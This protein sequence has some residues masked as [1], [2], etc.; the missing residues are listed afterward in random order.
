MSVS[1]T[2]YG[3]LTKQIR[4]DASPEVVYEVVSTPEHI[5]Q[6]WFDEA[7]FDPTEGSTGVLRMG[8]ATDRMETPGRMEV[9]IAVVEA[10]P[11]TRFSFR[12]VV[13]P[14]PAVSDETPLTAQ[15]SV[16]MSFD[17]VADGKGTLLTITEA[18]MRELG[19]E[20]ALLEDYYNS[21]GSVWDMLL[22]KL[23]AY[24]AKVATERDRG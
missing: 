9:P 2:E 13:P 7:D 22:T 19:W 5:A 15:N 18:G 23:P 21:H 6:W 10:I 1:Q 11:G 3:V 20:A 14:A 16:L 17:L 8:D 4:I 12:W 24:V